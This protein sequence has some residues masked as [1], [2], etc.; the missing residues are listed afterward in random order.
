MPQKQRAQLLHL[1]QA[2]DPNMVQ[3]HLEY[4]SGLEAAWRQSVVERGAAHAATHHAE[5]DAAETFKAAGKAVSDAAH[6]FS[7]HVRQGKDE[8]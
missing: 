1:H 5:Y 8:V 7:R 4:V 6:R 3:H 2:L